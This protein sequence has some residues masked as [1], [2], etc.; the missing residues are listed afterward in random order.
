MD[1]ACLQD[2]MAVIQHDELMS[3]IQCN[4][5]KL[6]TI[7]KQQKYMHNCLHWNLQKH[8]DKP[9]NEDNFVQLEAPS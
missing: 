3:T 2:R 4:R 8:K 5:K 7:R 1:F 6:K 9:N